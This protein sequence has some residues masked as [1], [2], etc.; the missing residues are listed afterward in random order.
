MKVN[1]TELDTADEAVLYCHYE[2]QSG[3]LDR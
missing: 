2:G 3:P 1:V